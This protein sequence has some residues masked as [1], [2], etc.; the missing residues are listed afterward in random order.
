MKAEKL[1]RRKASLFATSTIRSSSFPA[2]APAAQFERM[3]SQRRTKIAADE[4]A[5][6]ESFDHEA[7]PRVAGGCAS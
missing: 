2:R 5:D 7:T 1:A 3:T 6:Y 4:A